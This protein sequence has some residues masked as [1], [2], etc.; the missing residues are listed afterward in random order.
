MP[1]GRVLHT[2]WELDARDEQ[3]W[4]FRITVQH[5][6]LRRTGERPLELDVLRQLDNAGLRTLGMD[7]TERGH[8]K[9]CD[10]QGCD[11]QIHL[12]P[13]VTAL[14]PTLGDRREVA[15]QSHSSYVA[16]DYL[17][18]IGLAIAISP[19]VTIIGAACALLISG[20][21]PMTKLKTRN[22]G[23]PRCIK[24]RPTDGARVGQSLS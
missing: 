22:D 6:G 9:T 21:T 14:V 12:A 13:P 15:Q 1:M 2:G 19:P 24:E 16:Q 10:G 7:E 4:L 5:H 18:D 8:C 23:P 3:T 20:S 11:A 17:C